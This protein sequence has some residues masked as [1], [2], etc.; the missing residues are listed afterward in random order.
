MYSGLPVFALLLCVAAT[1]AR[2]V[3]PVNECWK[4]AFTEQLSGLARV[5]RTSS[6]SNGY[7]DSYDGAFKWSGKPTTAAI[8]SEYVFCFRKNIDDGGELYV[9]GKAIAFDRIGSIKRPPVSQELGFSSIAS[10]RDPR[11]YP[12]LY[13]VFA[14]P[15]KPDSSMEIQLDPFRRMVAVVVSSKSDRKRTVTYMQGP[16]TPVAAPASTP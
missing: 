8:K 9:N 14:T 10:V 11:E 5:Q 6:A 16:A 15:G 2:A 4:A 12:A 7:I 1:S 13:A 3:E